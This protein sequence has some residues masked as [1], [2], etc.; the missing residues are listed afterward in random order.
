MGSGLEQQQQLLPFT[1]A[2]ESYQIWDDSDPPETAH[3]G[4]AHSIM[5]SRKSYCATARYEDG[6]LRDLP[7]RVE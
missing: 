1:V 5:F 6:R 2:I 7:Q 3:R 4:R